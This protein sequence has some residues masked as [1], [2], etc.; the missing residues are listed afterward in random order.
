M[1]PVLVVDHLVKFYPG[2]LLVPAVDGI[3]FRLL[4]GEILG[5]VGPNGSGKTTT[6]QILLGTLAPSSGTVLYFGKD[7]V[8]HRSEL[9]QSISFASTY[10]SLPWNLSIAENLEIFGLIYGLSRTESHRKFDPLLERFGVADKKFKPVSELSAGQVTRLLLV[11][12]FFIDPK[13]VLLD[14]PTASLDPDIAKDICTF[15]LEQR[16]KKGISVL[17]TSHKMQ[18]V[19]EICDRTI[20]LKQ[21]KIIADDLPEKL[22]RSVSKFLVTLVIAEGLSR[23]VEIATSAGLDCKQ[24]HRTLEVSMDEEKIPPFL[25]ALSE[26]EVIYA[27][28]KID[29]PSL[30]DYFF[31]I[32]KKQI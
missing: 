27:S 17:F 26:A 3:S 24:D 2:N 7:F 20:F 10:A 9:L 30:E 21:G 11:K 31:E 16:D 18:E 12:A 25:R 22:A 19:M 29:E 6:I 32:T 23:A 28:I 15:L 14:E 4:E 1:D 5:L 13:I 8:E